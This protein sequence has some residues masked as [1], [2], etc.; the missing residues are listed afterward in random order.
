MEREEERECEGK[1]LSL[2]PDQTQMENEEKNIIFSPNRVRH[3]KTMWFELV[4]SQTTTATT[5][6]WVLNK[7]LLS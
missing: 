7:L 4:G 3:M 6:F 1:D 5:T 2:V